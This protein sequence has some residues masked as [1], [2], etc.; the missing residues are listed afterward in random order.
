MFI[1]FSESF[2]ARLAA[3]REPTRQ[4]RPFFPARLSPR[5]YCVLDIDR[6]TFIS[7]AATRRGSTPLSLLYFSSLLQSF[8][9]PCAPRG[10]S[11]GKALQSYNL[12][13]NRQNFQREILN[14]FSAP[15]VAPAAGTPG[16]GMRRPP[17]AALPCGKRVQNYAFQPTPPNFIPKIFPKI[18]FFNISRSRQKS[19]ANT[20]HCKPARYENTHKSPKIHSTFW[21]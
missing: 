19:Y 7:P 8:Q 5:K 12:F 2:R 9:C 14:F 4:R 13:P 15:G 21:I 3:A 17:P 1:F 16:T 20:H 18:M 11:P 6:V 10:L